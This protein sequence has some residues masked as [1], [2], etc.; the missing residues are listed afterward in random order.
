MKNFKKIA[1]AIAALS[2]AACM[3][4]PV[5]T[6]TSFAA[7]DV[8]ITVP[9]DGVTYSY[10]AYQIFTGVLSGGTLTEIQWGSGVDQTS[11]N[12]LSDIQGITVS[13][14]PTTPFSGKT[15]ASEIAKVLSDAAKTASDAEQPTK[16]LEI[17]KKFADVI[18]KHLKATEGTSGTWDSTAKQIKG[19]EDGYYLIQDTSSSPSGAGEKNSG[20]KTRYMLE[21]IGDDADGE[22]AEAKTSAPEVMKKVKEESLVGDATE[23]ASFAG[24]DSYEVGDGYNDIAD[25]DIGD[26]VPFQL[27]GSMPETLNDYEH[28]YYKFTD[29][30]GTEFTAP[31]QS[32]IKVYIGSEDVTNQATIKVDDHTITVEFTDIRALTLASETLTK[33]SIVTVKY[34]AKL[35]S[36]AK[37]GIPGQR[38]KVKL[39]Y[40]NNPNSEWDGSNTPEDTDTGETPEDGVIVFTYGIDIDKRE[41]TAGGTKLENAKF[42]VYKLVDGEKQYIKAKDGKYTGTTPTAPDTESGTTETGLFTSA[43][44]DVN[45]VIAGLD[46]GDYFI[47]ELEAPATYNKLNKTIKVTVTATM[48]DD[49]QAWTFGET[50]TEAQKAL[51]A[52]TVANEQGDVTDKAGS[53]EYKKDDTIT[54]STDKI[55]GKADG[56]YEDGHSATDQ[57]G[58]VVVINNKGATL[59]STGGIGTTLFYLGGG[60]LVAVAGVMLITKKRMTKE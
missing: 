55:D 45:I 30:L 8:T 26:D 50:E 11:A 37:I 54:G 32:A 3:V 51:T 20:A 36:D 25:Y 14:A 18:S 49:R 43:T 1:S 60:A 29:T 44:G 6:M 4:A 46:A 59:P 24:D 19:L 52:L 56:Y 7:T 35:S 39:T 41:E 53:F 15:T 33:D 31:A 40:S 27:Y 2:L 58:T 17:T 34:S 12:L 28:Y 48:A 21:V 22:K 57:L 23:T 42:A 13:E 38:N 9:N 16:D 10:E 5:A 47:E